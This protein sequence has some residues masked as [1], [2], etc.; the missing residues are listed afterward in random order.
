MVIMNFERSELDFVSK[1]LFEMIFFFFVSQI[2]VPHGY[3]IEI[4]KWAFILMEF[5]GF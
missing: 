4:L 3:I 1:S 2:F 5:I